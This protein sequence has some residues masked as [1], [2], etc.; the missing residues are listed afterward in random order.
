[1]LGRFDAST[2]YHTFAWGELK[3]H[4]GW[5]V[6]RL[7]GE[8]RGEPLALAQILIRRLPL[9]VAVAWVPGGPLGPPQAWS[10]SLGTGLRTALDVN[11]LYLRINSMQTE[12]EAASASLRRA[13]WRRPRHA[14]VSGQSVLLPLEDDHDAWLR[15]IDQKHRYY[16]RRSSAAG[17][18]WAHGH[19]EHLRNDLAALLSALR[20]EKRVPVETI[21][22]AGLELLENA[23]PGTVAIVV[24]YLDGAPVTG[25]LALVHR[26]SAWYIAA[27]TNG[28]GRQASAAYA[29]LAE[30]RCVLRARGVR[31][32]DFGG[33]DPASASA[34]G[35][36]HFKLGFG[37]DRVR[38]LGE[39]HWATSSLVRYA[40]D[41][42]IHRRPA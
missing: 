40:M 37:G 11:A 28:Q 15:S 4:A 1:M 7:I 23:T 25:C 6:V 27:A 9:G 29:M 39:W 26:A 21:P 42:L 10:A 5:I 16:V 18:S 33:I 19:E 12:D 30:L 41:E 17:L 22:S 8:A 34:R 13:G 31:V 2:V 14:M 36:D 32:L 35:V 3:R 20:E 38:Y 24:G